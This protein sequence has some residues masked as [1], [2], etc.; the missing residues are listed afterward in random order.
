M[1]RELGD[2]NEEILGRLWGE[3]LDRCKEKIFKRLWRER[4]KRVKKVKEEE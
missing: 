1:V 2:R 4:E 3:D